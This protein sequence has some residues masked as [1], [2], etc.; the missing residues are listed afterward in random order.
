MVNQT[1]SYCI[2]IF[3]YILNIDLDVRVLP[4]EKVI[5]KKNGKLLQIKINLKYVLI[6]NIE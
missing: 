1:E 3:L 4:T 6:L 5:G 2:F